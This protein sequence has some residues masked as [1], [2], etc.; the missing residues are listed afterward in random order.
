[1]AMCSKVPSQ[2]WREALLEPR[3]LH[4]THERGSPRVIPESQLSLL[5]ENSARPVGPIFEFCPLCDP[6]VEQDLEPGNGITRSPLDRHILNHL[7]FLAIR[8]LPWND[9]GKDSVS[10]DRTTRP[11]T[12]GTVRE[13]LDEKLDLDLDDSSSHREMHF[14]LDDSSNYTP[15]GPIS[16]ENEWGSIISAQAAPISRFDPILHSFRTWSDYVSCK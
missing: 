14:P 10:S 2:E 1:M 16:R 4:V 12:R 13:T 11:P 5:A 6:N 7:I 3:G 15:N 8:S 9:D